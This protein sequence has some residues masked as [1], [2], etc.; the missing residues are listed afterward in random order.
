MIPDHKRSPFLV[1]LPLV[2]SCRWLSISDAVEHHA[3]A[4][5]RPARV[6]DASDEYE[7]HKDAP[8]DSDHDG[9][10][11]VARTHVSGEL[12]EGK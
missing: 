4:T 9:A 7:S 2:V 11:V 3:P 1:E 8:E 5:S 10:P 6:L 12:P